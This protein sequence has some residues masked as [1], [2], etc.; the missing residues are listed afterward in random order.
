MIYAQISSGHKLHLAC[1]PG[2]EYFGQVI[3][4]GHLSAPLCRTRAFNGHYR[5]TVNLPLN[6]SCMNC[7]R[8]AAAQRQG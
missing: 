2:E 8:V 7:R 3:P 4:A 5:M 6:H 1:Q